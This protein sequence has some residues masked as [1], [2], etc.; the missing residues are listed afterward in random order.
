VGTGT[1]LSTVG[2]DWVVEQGCMQ[3]SAR[4]SRYFI[5]YSEDKTVG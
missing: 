2:N 4:A 1:T 5:A 3:G